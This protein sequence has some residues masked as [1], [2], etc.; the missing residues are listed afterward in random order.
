MTPDRTDDGVLEPED[1]TLDPE[2]VDRID[3]NRFVV[4]P[5]ESGEP[6]R[7]SDPS[8]A[9]GPAETVRVPDDEPSGQTTQ[10]DLTSAFDDEHSGQSDATQAREPSPTDVLAADPAP[11]GVDISL[12]TDGEVARH[13]GTSSDIREVFADMM[14]W[15]ASQ[16]DEEVT[17]MQALEVLVATTDLDERA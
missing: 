6:T 14:A 7:A 12:K 1:L 11:H 3:D 4:K 15:Y 5:D 10:T 16:L 13:R 9:L 17:P 2:H 8:T